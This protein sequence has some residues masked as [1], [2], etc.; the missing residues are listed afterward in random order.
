MNVAVLVPRR[1][2]DGWRDG[3]WQVAGGW[4]RNTFPEWAVVEGVHDDGPF[5]RSAAAN[6]A[7]MDAGEWDVAVV[8]DADVMTYRSPVLAAVRIGA[9]TGDLVVAFNERAHVRR[10]VTERIVEGEV[11]PD[12]DVC[13]DHVESS[14]WSGCVVIRRDLWDAVDGF[15]EA[16][17]GYGFEDIAFVWA[18]WS[19]LGR[20]HVTLS[21]RLFHLWHPS[22]KP[23]DHDSE[24]V[25]NRLLCDRY[26]RAAALATG[27]SL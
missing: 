2:D 27:E 11:F 15:D 23:A 26:R 3:L 9:A 14:I 6:A 21:N 19:A 13:V 1:A 17:V 22:A 8:I 24:Y 5:N 4:W 12:L 18:C 25:T 7:A 20:P 16:F 10:D